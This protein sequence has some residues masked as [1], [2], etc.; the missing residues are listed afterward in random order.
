MNLSFFSLNLESSLHT[1]LPFCLQLKLFFPVVTFA[2]PKSSRNSSI[3]KDF[4]SLLLSCYI[5][6]CIFFVC[7]VSHDYVG[8]FT[9]S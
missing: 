2:K 6:I 5:L 8:G 9:I 7:L 3:G 4:N 1:V